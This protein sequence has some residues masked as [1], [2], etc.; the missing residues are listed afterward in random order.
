MSAACPRPGC[1]GDTLPCPRGWRESDPALR[2]YF[3]PLS[4]PSPGLATQHE[5]GSG[6]DTR[7]AKTVPHCTLSS[8]T[9]PS[10]LGGSLA[11]FPKVLS[12]LSGTRHTQEGQP[13]EF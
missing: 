13:W 6:K 9:L 11:V 8:L 3:I 1:R 10:V 2:V 5:G 7:L 12:S 4:H